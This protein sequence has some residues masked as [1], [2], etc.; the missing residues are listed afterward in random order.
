MCTLYKTKKSRASLTY[1]YSRSG[2]QFPLPVSY[3]RQNAAMLLWKSHLLW[4]HIVTYTSLWCVAGAVLTDL[5]FSL[6]M[7]VFCSFHHRNILFFFLTHV[8]TVCVSLW[9][10]LDTEVCCVLCSTHDWLNDT[11]TANLTDIL[12]QHH[13]MQFYIALYCSSAMFYSCSVLVARK[14]VAVQIVIMLIF[15]MTCKHRGK[16][17]YRWI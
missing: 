17:R 8:G 15:C 2:F 6:L 10:M 1:L 5:Y 4:R 13:M 3:T 12:M 11:V 7:F 14:S 9:K 16:H